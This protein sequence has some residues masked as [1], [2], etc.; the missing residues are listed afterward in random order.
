MRK[1]QAARDRRAV[2]DPAEQIVLVG[3]R[4]IG[5]DSPDLRAN[6]DVFARQADARGTVE[7]DAPE[8]AFG[9]IADKEDR[10]LAPGEI[11]LEMMADTAAFAHARRGKND[12]ARDAVE[13]DRRVDVLDEMKGGMIEDLAVDIFERLRIFGENSRRAARER[14]IDENARRRY[15]PAVNQRGQVEQQFLRPLE[16]EDRNDEVAAPVERRLH[17]GTEQTASF[18]DRHMIAHAI[19]VGRFANDMVEARRTFGIGMKGLMFGAKIART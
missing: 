17:L 6:R 13:P 12:R 9:L 8:R 5:V 2:F 14:R 3:M 10:R 16:R 1:E 15:L 19:A 4:R 18:L 11:M 7:N